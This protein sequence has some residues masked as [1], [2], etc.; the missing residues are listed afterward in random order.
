MPLE[1]IGRLALESG[2][3]RID[4]DIFYLAFGRLAE[5][6]DNVVLV[7]HGLTSGPQML[8][9][10]DSV[11][12]EGTWC[13]LVG[14][15]RAIDTDRFYVVCPNMLGSCYGSTGP[16]SIDPATG[17][18]YGGRFPDLSVRDIVSSQRALLQALEVEHLHAVV[19]P[20]YGG[21]QALQ[22][23]IDFPEFVESLGVVVSGAKF[24][25]KLTVESVET[26]LTGDPNWNQGDYYESGGIGETMKRL[27]VDTLL[28]YG[29]YEVLIDQGMSHDRCL[30]TIDTLAET[31][32]RE[33]DGHS[34]LTLVRAGARFDVRAM[35]PDIA[36][37]LLWVTSSSDK[38]FPPSDE[39]RTLLNRSEAPSR[40]TYV[41]L[42]SRYGH[43]AS[44]ADY[45]KWE[46]ALR[47]LLA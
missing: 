9:E 2:A 24:P 26:V 47:D 45:R 38:V 5:S 8:L 28:Q 3:D 6:R 7:T 43:V 30:E 35:L 31:W 13:N 37:R 19:G 33:F 27:R 34:L 10:S 42:D 25:E 18:R 16:R 32:S 44:G 20:S 4:A 39:V 11:T 29:M 14:P 22:W 1:N 36:A 17:G 12:G 21:I 41:E 15:G 23:A 40:P 46:G